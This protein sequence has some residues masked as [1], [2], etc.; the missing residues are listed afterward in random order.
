[1]FYFNL[2][3]ISAE[4]FLILNSILSQSNNYIY[5]GGRYMSRKKYAK[6]H[7]RRVEKRHS[8]LLTPD[9]STYV[10][11]THKDN[12]SDLFSG[13]EKSCCN[14]IMHSMDRIIRMKEN[15]VSLRWKPGTVQTVVGIFLLY[16]LYPGKSKGR[17]YS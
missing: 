14:Y 12:C 8:A 10:R 17:K 1:M 3:Y 9:N 7:K 15:C 13:T 5:N 11:R 16:L 2:T 4:I 6:G